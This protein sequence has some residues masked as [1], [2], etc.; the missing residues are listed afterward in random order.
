MRSSRNFSERQQK[1]KRA[2]GADT[3]YTPQMVVDGRMELIG[4]L[5]ERVR[6]A[7]ARGRRRHPRRR[8][9]STSLAL[10]RAIL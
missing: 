7:V 1:Y 4:S 5:G 8:S 6:G 2:L 3:L 10:A 9:R